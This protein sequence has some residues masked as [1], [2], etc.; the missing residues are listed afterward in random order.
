MWPPSYSYLKRQST[1]FV[2]SYI[3]RYEPRRTSSKVLGVMRG[4]RV[5]SSDKVCGRRRPCSESLTARGFVDG[6]KRL[7]ALLLRAVHTFCF[8][9]CTLGSRVS[10]ADLDR[11][12]GLTSRSWTDIKS[13]GIAT[14]ICSVRAERKLSGREQISS[15]GSGVLTSTAVDS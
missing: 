1:S 15:K 2:L 10:P 12:L 6:S 3:D 8:L 11:L 9:R 13:Y 7:K 5:E 4:M 14:T